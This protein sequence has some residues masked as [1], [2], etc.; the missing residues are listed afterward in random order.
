MGRRLMNNPVDHP[1]EWLNGLS[2]RTANVLLREG[3]FSKEQLVELVN[4]VDEH[5]PLRGLRVIPDMGKVGV[6]EVLE[7]LGIDQHA[8]ENFHKLRGLRANR[9]FQKAK[10]L[11][12]SMGYEVRRRA[13]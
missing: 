3:I 4:R 6:A 13:G 5:A 11:L 1:D 12:E 9:K 7:W 10:D 2:T 8:R